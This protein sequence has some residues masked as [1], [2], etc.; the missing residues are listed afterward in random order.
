MYLYLDQCGVYIVGRISVRRIYSL[1][2]MRYIDGVLLGVDVV[3][4]LIGAMCELEDDVSEWCDALGKKTGE[5]GIDVDQH[6]ASNLRT[7]RRHQPTLG[8]AGAGVAGASA[9]SMGDDEAVE[10]DDEA[11]DEDDNRYFI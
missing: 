5:R 3:S 10:S 4:V 6:N 7:F 8:A 9:A 11:D 1:D 2:R